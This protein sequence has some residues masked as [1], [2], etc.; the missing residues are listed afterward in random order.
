[1]G[2]ARPT[3]SGASASTSDVSVRPACRSAAPGRGSHA[4]TRR[5]SA[6]SRATARTSGSALPPCQEARTTASK[7]SALRTSSTSASSRASCPSDRVPG[8]PAC[9][10]LDPYGSAGGD[11]HVV[12]RRTDRLGH[13]DGDQRVRLQG[14]VRPVLLRRPERDDEHERPRPLQVRPRGRAEP[15]RP[16]LTAALR[17]G[18]RP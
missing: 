13:R 7:R 9:S 6:R 5:P 15:H 14:Q 2:R 8:K 1:M 10:P 4:T 3:R 12:A 16:T 11:R 18:R 17:G